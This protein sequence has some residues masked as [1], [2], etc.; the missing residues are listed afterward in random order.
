[1][2]FKSHPGSVTSFGV[3]SSSISSHTLAGVR[4][5]FTPVNKDP[6]SLFDFRKKKVNGL[7]SAARQ[8]S[9][10]SFAAAEPAVFVQQANSD[11]DFRMTDTKKLSAKALVALA[12]SS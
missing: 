2:A 3:S 6:L 4:T 11:R 8:P 1:M 10:H 12:F 9:W 5:P 7:R